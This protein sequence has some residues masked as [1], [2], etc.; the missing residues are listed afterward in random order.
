MA[1][2]KNIEHVIK[3]ALNRGF[4][5]LSRTYSGS[6][7]KYSWKCSQ[8]H[9]WQAQF[10]PIRDGIGCPYCSGRCR[11]I[12]SLKNLANKHDIEYV[13]EQNIY[14][15]RCQEGH[16]WECRPHII[17]SGKGCPICTSEVTLE[18][19][20][21]FILEQLTEKKFPKTRKTL[22]GL[23]L[24]GY[25]Q[26]LNVAF[27]FQGPQ[28]YQKHFWH[29][30]A[31]SFEM[32]IER[33]KRK[34]NL[35]KTLNIY[36]IDIPYFECKNKTMMEKFI[37]SKIGIHKTI[38]WS[39]FKG[40]PSLFR[41]LCDYA[42]LKGFIC[43]STTYFGAT[44]KLKWKCSKNH[45]WESS[46]AN[47]KSGYGCPYCSKKAKKTIKDMHDLAKLRGFFFLSTKYSN[48]MTKHL[49]AC[50]HKHRWMARPNCIQQGRGCPKCVQKK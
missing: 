26:E 44:T 43:L 9:K 45:E 50:Q 3:I 4:E 6:K 16:K 49:W 27:E 30:K 40:S 47:I 22:K 2:K 21:R 12:D 11:T 48:V 33:D 23:E 15:W 32:Q 41:S 25:C 13:G 18:D 1:K 35:C 42:A 38:D 29:K 5:L 19:K 24:D 10:G 8:G 37:S 14:Q 39:T 34:C 28:H 17:A 7:S 46:P 31:N 36:K 20:C